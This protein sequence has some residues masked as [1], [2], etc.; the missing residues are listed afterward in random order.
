MGAGQARPSE[1]ASERSEVPHRGGVLEAADIFCKWYPKKPNKFYFLIN[2][3]YLIRL[4]LLV[5]CQN[6]IWNVHI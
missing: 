2:Y 3:V 5:V 6:Q 1:R 4:R